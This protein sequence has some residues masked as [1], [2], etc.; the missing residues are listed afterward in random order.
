MTS[1]ANASVTELHY[2]ERRIGLHSFNLT[3]HLPDDLVT[4][5]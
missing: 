4:R 5:V 2:T 1:V 3:A